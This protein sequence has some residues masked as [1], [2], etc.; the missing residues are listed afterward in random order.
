M[1]SAFVS[2]LALAFATTALQASVIETGS[3]RYDYALA[4][5]SGGSDGPY[6]NNGPTIYG[7]FDDTTTA[8]ASDSGGSG[9]ARGQQ[10]SSID[11]GLYV[12]DLEAY[13]SASAVAFESGSA[14]S[15][16]YF[17]VDFTLSSAADFTLDGNAS[18][19]GGDSVMQISLANVG[20]GGT[21]TQSLVNFIGGN[22]STPLSFAGSLLPGDYE[23]RAHAFTDIS[24][25]FEF[26]D[27][28]NSSTAAADFTFTLTPEPASFALVLLG[29]FVTLRRRRAA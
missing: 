9:D 4:A 1:K 7:N 15:D 24:Y 21:P 18:V 2:A 3:D 19:N 6:Q 8:T 20:S 28:S 16:A 29:G 5:S 23:L 13:A 12:A 14:R 26:D 22:A 25:F 11:P 27:L 10:T 17:E